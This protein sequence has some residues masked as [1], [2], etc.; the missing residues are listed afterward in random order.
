MISAGTKPMRWIALGSLAMMM[1]HSTY[2][3]DC[4]PPVTVIETTTIWADDSWPTS[5][6]TQF[7]HPDN[8]PPEPRYSCY[9]VSTTTVSAPFPHATIQMV[10]PQEQRGENEQDEMEHD[11]SKIEDEDCDNE[12]PQS[13]IH[14]IPAPTITVPN[15]P[16]PSAPTGPACVHYVTT[17]GLAPCPTYTPLPLNSDGCAILTSTSLALA[18]ATAVPERPLCK[19]DGIVV[20]VAYTYSIGSEPTHPRKHKHKHPKS[21]IT[22]VPEPR[23]P[24]MVPS[25]VPQLDDPTEISNSLMTHLSNRYRYTLSF[26]F[27]YGTTT[28]PPPRIMRYPELPGPTTPPGTTRAAGPGPDPTSAP[29]SDPPAPVADP[30]TSGAPAPPPTPE[31]MPP[32]PAPDTTTTLVV[33]PPGSTPAED[34]LVDNIE[35]VDPLPV[36]DLP[37]P[38]SPGADP[39]IAVDPPAPGPTPTPTIHKACDACAEPCVVKVDVVVKAEVPL[40]V[41]LFQDKIKSALASLRISLENETGAAATGADDA[42]GVFGNLSVDVNAETAGVFRKA[43]ETKLRE[44]EARQFAGLSAKAGQVAGPTCETGVC[45][46][47]EVDK[48]VRLLDFMVSTE[49]ARDASQLRVEL[50]HEFKTKYAEEGRKQAALAASVDAD[51]TIE[52]RGGLGR[53]LGPAVGGTLDK[54]VDEVGDVVGGVI[55]QASPPLGDLVKGLV[56][57]L[58]GTVKSVVDSFVGNCNRKGLLDFDTEHGVGSLEAI[59]NVSLDLFKLVCV[60]A[61]VDVKV[62]AAPK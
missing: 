24:P 52:K 49:L 54:V 57:V 26:E 21:T 31:P 14:D 59:T 29:P 17:M 6:V 15:L 2:A 30:T 33:P 37:T 1:L 34:P 16:V 11:S 40:L 20:D 7:V 38:T 48:A 61:D 45:V 9:V 25:H 60:K 28:K 47:R 41:R 18:T 39:V 50:V 12:D 55:T 42:A 10:L 58:T 27:N 23:L 35:V 62:D 36:V 5:T 22:P 43:C 4:P 8:C 56:G 53:L 46:Q 13:A 51:A 32:V 3:E 44:I 19:E